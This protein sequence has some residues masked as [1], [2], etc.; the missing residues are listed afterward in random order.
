MHL[1][2]STFIAGVGARRLVARAGRYLS[3]AARLDCR[4]E[5]QSNGESY[6][7]SRLAELHQSDNNPV[8]L[9]IGANQG[10][11][12]RALIGQ[13]K[14][15]NRRA[16]RIHAF[17]PVIDSYLLLANNLQQ[18]VESGIVVLVNAG[19]SDERRQSEISITGYAAGTNALQPDP[20]LPDLPKQRV[21]LWSIDTYCKENNIDHLSYAKID[22][23]GHDLYVLKGANHMM[24]RQA[25]DCLQFEYNHRWIWS[26]TFLRDAFIIAEA[27]GYVIG[28]LTPIGVE[29][30][31]RWHPELEKYVE[32]NYLMYPNNNPLRLHHF[33]WWER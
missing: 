31:E 19:A 9:D 13:Y 24:K 1:A 15:T 21:N 2:L 27:H 28:K 12:T 22:V 8:I 7:H 33:P 26:R 11:W 4:N 14:L 3:S 20:T 25:I 29:L 32:G 23:E 17:E 18:Y 6:V 5:I 10:E 16:P 30:Y